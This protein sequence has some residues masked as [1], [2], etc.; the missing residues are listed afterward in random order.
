LIGAKPPLLARHVWSIRTKLQIERRARELAMF[1][2]AI[3]SKLR[4]CHC[5][6]D[7]RSNPNIL[8]RPVYITFRTLDMPA[9]RCGY[10]SARSPTSPSILRLVFGNAVLMDA[11]ERQSPGGWGAARPGLRPPLFGGTKRGSRSAVCPI[12]MGRSSHP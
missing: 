3:D 4:G 11:G 1:N 9:E 7:P 8:I 12:S 2:L 5:E 10:G 6:A